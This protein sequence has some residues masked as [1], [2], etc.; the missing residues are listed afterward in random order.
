MREQR[1]VS[2]KNKN[3]IEKRILEYTTKSPWE[4]K[5]FCFGEKEVDF[6]CQASDIFECLLKLIEEYLEKKIS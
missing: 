6:L 5:L 4:L 2:I 3:S 1:I